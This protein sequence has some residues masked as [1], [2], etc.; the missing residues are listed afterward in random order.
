[1]WSGGDMPDFT[2]VAYLAMF[3]FVCAVVG[4]IGG[5]GWLI[6]FVINHVRIV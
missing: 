1:M 2:G 5:L 3:G 4:G 6:W